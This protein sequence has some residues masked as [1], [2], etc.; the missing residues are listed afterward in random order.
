MHDILYERQV[1][2]ELE[3]LVAYAQ[4]LGLDLDRFQIEVVQGVQAPRVRQDFISGVRSGVNGTPTFFINGRRHDGAWDLQT[5]STAIV[6]AMNWHAAEQGPGQ[7]HGH[8]R[9][10][11]RHA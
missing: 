2:L 1:A 10:H 7:G 11:G 8:G 6:S 5:L 9:H 3:D 4:E